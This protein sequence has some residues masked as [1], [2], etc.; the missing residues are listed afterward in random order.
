MCDRPRQRRE[1]REQRRA[2]THH[3][4]R[5]RTYALCRHLFCEPLFNNSRRVAVYLPADGEVDTSAIIERAWQMG[6]QV[7]LPVLVPFLDNRLWFARY[8]PDTPL[9]RNRFGIAEP[10]QVHRQRIKP[11]ALD[12]VLAP[13]VGFDAAGN[14][15]GMGGGFYDRSF[16][17]LLRHRAWRKPHLVGLAYNF[18]QL[19]RLPAQAWDVPLTAVVTDDGWHHFAVRPW[20]VPASQPQG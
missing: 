15:L 17:F 4:R 5:Q 11:L 10:E 20:A 8:L 18:Q 14:R 13:L 1:L 3:E 16:S 12:L 19:P 2:L 9:V 7:Y 6:K